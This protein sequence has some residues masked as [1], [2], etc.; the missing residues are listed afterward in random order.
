M[1]NDKY[2]DLKITYSLKCRKMVNT[3]NYMIDVLQTD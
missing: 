3:E 1:I 2:N